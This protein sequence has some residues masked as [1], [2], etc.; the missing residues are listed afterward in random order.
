MHDG[1]STS[2]LLF[3]DNIRWTMIILVLSMHASDTYSPFGN[4][5]YTE[6]PKIG[7][8]TILMFAFYQ[9]F[10][11]AFFM[12]LLFF[13]AGFF[14]APSYDR[15]GFAAFARERCIRLGVPT[16]LFM[17][18][19]GPLTQY[20]LSHT[21]GD[22]G[23][24]Y[25]WRLHIIDGQILSET[26]PMWFAALLLLFS[27]LYATA[28][29]VARAL[30]RV[31][32]HSCFG[33]AQLIAFIGT[34]SVATFLV[35]I[36][37]PENASVL[38]THP[39]DF[40]QYILMFVAGIIA[41]RRGWLEGAS[42]MF[43]VRWAAVLTITSI[44]LF[45]LLAAGGGALHG[46]T[47]DYSGGLNA[48]SLLK[49]VWESMVCVGMTLALVSLYRRKFNRQGALATWLSR[50]AFAVYLCHPPIIIALAILTQ[51]IQ[52]PALIK[53]ILLTLATAIVTYSL[54][55]T[56]LRRTP[57]LRRIL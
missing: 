28:R 24:P 48:M 21:W 54:V 27:L 46:H 39:A 26:G 7:A 25:Q 52:A 32:H 1:S 30:P 41:A 8:M 47:A 9:S 2:R 38:N 57:L 6:H 19:I 18:V 35:R 31:Q 4:W 14:A 29:L 36:W 37:L 12:A 53:V 23:F 56:V 3:I 15:K 33:N 42:T 51:R 22:G 49:C 34:M 50:D 13:I 20:Y 17:F 11:Q 55:S 5:Y 10:L 43:S 40:P 16:L 44:P 45:A